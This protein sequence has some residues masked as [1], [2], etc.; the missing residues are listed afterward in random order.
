MSFPNGSPD[1]D[2]AYT[3]AAEGSA[4]SCAGTVS[5]S[6]YTCDLRGDVSNGSSVTVEGLVVTT[7][8]GGGGVSATAIYWLSGAFGSQLLGLY[9]DVGDL[10]VVVPD[11]SDVRLAAGALW[12]PENDIL[13]APADAATNVT[14]STVFS[15][16]D[17]DAAL[18]VFSFSNVVVNGTSGIVSIATTSNSVT[19]ATLEARGYALSSG[20]THVWTVRRFTGAGGVN[21][22]VGNIQQLRHDGSARVASESRTFTTQ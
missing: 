13:T 5:A 1:G 8:A 3:V 14:S 10:T 11:S 4:S 20:S 17:S 19:L 7:D 16:T 12:L 2:A 21:D 22:G 9:E 18:N 15:V 6:T